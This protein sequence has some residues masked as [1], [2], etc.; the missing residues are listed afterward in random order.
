MIIL[1][2]LLILAI[3]LLFMGA[4]ETHIIPNLEPDNKFLLWWKEHIINEDP[5]EK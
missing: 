3:I 5:F 1:I 4:I 2:V